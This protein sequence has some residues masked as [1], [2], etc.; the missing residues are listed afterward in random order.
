MKPPDNMKFPDTFRR[1]PCPFQNLAHGEFKGPLLPP[2]TAESAESASIHTDIC[3]ID[4][5][6]L[7]KVNVVSVAE[8]GGVGRQSSEAEDIL[9]PEEP[10]GIIRRKSFS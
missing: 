4:V 9:R 5:P 2:G 10:K 6:V 3:G 8:T 1:L 7:N